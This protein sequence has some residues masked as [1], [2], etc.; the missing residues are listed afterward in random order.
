MRAHRR[1]QSARPQGM[2]LANL[3]REAKGGACPEWHKVKPN[4][5]FSDDFKSEFIHVYPCKNSFLV[6][7]LCAIRACPPLL[8]SYTSLLV[9]AFAKLHLSKRGGLKKNAQDA[10]PS[11]FGIYQKMEEKN[12][13]VS[14]GTLT[15]RFYRLIDYF[16]AF[17]RR[18]S[19]LA[20]ALFISAA[21]LLASAWRPWESICWYRL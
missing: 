2:S 14:P 8:R 13:G 10:Y 6:A 11:L 12:P 19:Y 9:L 4:F 21:T 16:P 17:A 18:S 20:L 5:D 7:Y 15:Y 3:L 1:A